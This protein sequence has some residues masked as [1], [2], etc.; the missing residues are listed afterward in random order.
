VRDSQATQVC[1][2][3]EIYVFLHTIMLLRCAT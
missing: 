1:I 2:R 3:Q